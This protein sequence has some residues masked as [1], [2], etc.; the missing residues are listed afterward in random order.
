MPGQLYLSNY[1]GS[2]DES[3]DLFQALFSINLYP[4]AQIHTQHPVCQRT[5]RSYRLC[6]IS[7]LQAPSQQDGEIHILL[8]RSLDPRNVKQGTRSS[9]GIKKRERV[10]A[11]D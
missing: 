10:V 11:P 2:L 7:E 6:N 9:A 5:Q 4:A 3:F 8:Q 1:L